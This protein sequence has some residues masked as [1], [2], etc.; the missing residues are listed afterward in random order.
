MA[1]NLIGK[2]VRLVR[3]HN[4]ITKLYGSVHENEVGLCID[5]S[6]Y[7]NSI[8]TSV[9]YEVIPEIKRGSF[10]Y[11]VSKWHK[12]DCVLEK[13]QYEIEELLTCSNEEVREFALRKMK[14]L[15]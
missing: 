9:Y 2:R 7:Y 10:Y 8:G 6:E 12:D 3:I 4:T 5:Q 1:P 15:K 13:S 11:V 14:K